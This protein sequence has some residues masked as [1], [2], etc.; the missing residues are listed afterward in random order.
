MAILNLFSFQRLKSNKITLFTAITTSYDMLVNDI[1]NYT[2][3]NFDEEAI[4]TFFI[5]II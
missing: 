3:S 4:D 2:K 5:Y 1:V